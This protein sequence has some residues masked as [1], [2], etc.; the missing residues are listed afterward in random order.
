MSCK[1][2]FN[3][4]NQ[5]ELEEYIQQLA[6]NREAYCALSAIL[7]DIRSKIKYSEESTTS[8]EAVRELIYEHTGYYKLSDEF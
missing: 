3:F 5:Y 1:L 8:W 6:S 7:Q 4:E 2:E